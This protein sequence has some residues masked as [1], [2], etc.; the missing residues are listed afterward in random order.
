VAVLQS[1]KSIEHRVFLFSSLKCEPW[2]FG[3]DYINTINGLGIQ[4]ILPSKASQHIAF[5]IVLLVSAGLHWYVYANLQRVLLRDYPKLGK[6]LAKI[7]RWV[8]ILLDTPFV[9]IYLR[10]SLHAAMTVLSRVLLYP[11]LIWQTIM[12]MWVI[13]LFPITLFRW[14]KRFGTNL[15]VVQE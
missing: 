6:R 12:L 14:V 2:C 5:F 11:F 7:A 10:G 3:M 1:W 9:F 13:I 4:S 8:F 15:N